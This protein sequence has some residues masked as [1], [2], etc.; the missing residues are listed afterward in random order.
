V[1][2]EQKITFLIRAAWDIEGA[3]VVP[4]YFD[5]YTDEELDKQVDFYDYLYDK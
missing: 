3:V 2:R 1:T 4:S 5:K